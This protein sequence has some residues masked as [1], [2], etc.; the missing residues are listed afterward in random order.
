MSRDTVKNTPPYDLENPAPF[1][2]VGK[3]TYYLSYANGG[4]CYDEND[5]AQM[6]KVNAVTGGEKLSVFMTNALKL[7]QESE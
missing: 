5:A 6:A 1:K 2:T 7:L 4:T 3:Y